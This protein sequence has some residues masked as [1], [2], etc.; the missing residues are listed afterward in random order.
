MKMIARQKMNFV[1]YPWKRTADHSNGPSRTTIAS[2]AT[3]NARSKSGSRFVRL[4]ASE[5]GGPLIEFAF[6]LPLMMICLTG[7]FTFGIAI[8]NALVL[9]QATG[10]GAQYLQTIRT[11]ATDPCA[12]TFSAIT[13]AAPNLNS[14]NITLTLSIN[15]GTATTAKTCTGQLTALQGASGEPVTVS[16][17]YPCTLVVYGLNLGGCQLKANVTE[18]EY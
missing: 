14:S 10:T 2:D 17:T 11:T 6:V 3:V 12:N 7:I 1:R 8:Y 16:T 13:T 9:T 4:L 18:Y 5:D 15:N